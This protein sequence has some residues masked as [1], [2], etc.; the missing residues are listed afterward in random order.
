MQDKL[1][2][3]LVEAAR[4]C[5]MSRTHFREHVDPQLK[6]VR[7]G[8]ARRVLVCELEHWAE[9]NSTSIVDDLKRK[10]RAA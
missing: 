9:M 10:R 3:G 6:W 7:V 2:V 8:A 1:L 4:L 5:S